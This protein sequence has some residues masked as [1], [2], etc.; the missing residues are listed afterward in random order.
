MPS[1][2]ENALTAAIDAVNAG[3]P[4]KR[5]AHDYGIPR[6]T[7]Q[8]RLAGRQPKTTVHTSQQKLSPIQESRLAEWIC[9][10]DTLG[11]APTHTQIRTFASRILLAGGSATGVGKH[12]LEG[13]LRR[14]P[15]V[16]TLQT[17]RM[18]ATRMN[19]ATTE[20]IQA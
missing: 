16:K 20:V 9:V 14:N 12:W 2:T 19:G 7:L 8:H 5:V 3:I 17:R 18:D 6:T 15:R 10:Q 11:L 4:V 13:F 1:Y